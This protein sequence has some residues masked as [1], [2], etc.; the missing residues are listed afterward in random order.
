M[1]DDKHV[2]VAGVDGGARV[3]VFA[4]ELELG[5][6]KSCG[7]RKAGRSVCVCVCESEN[8]CMCVCVCHFV[9]V[10][11]KKKTHQ[12]RCGQDEG[13]PAVGKSWARGGKLKSQRPRIF[14]LQAKD[15]VAMYYQES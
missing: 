2:D 14:A 13:G 4:Q 9:R 8:P 11:K 5:V 7:E 15:K 10:E 3:C 12:G 1:W 6:S